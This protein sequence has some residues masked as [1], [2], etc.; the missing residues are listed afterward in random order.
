MDEP[1]PRPHPHQPS[2]IEKHLLIHSHWT[3]G[4]VQVMFL[5][6]SWPRCQL[7]FVPINCLQSNANGHKL[8]LRQPRH[9]ASLTYSSLSIFFFKCKHT[10]GSHTMPMCFLLTFFSSCSRGEINSPTTLCAFQN[11]RCWLSVRFVKE[12]GNQERLRLSLGPESTNLESN[13]SIF[14]S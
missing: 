5:S 12:E 3:M 13:W 9:F 2:Q 8:L 14:R 6:S 4:I 7:D 11:G 10:E 1:W